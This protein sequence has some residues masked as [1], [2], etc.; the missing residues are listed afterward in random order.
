MCSVPY[1][2]RIV[3]ELAGEVG[4]VSFEAIQAKGHV[5]YR[6]GLGLN[7]YASF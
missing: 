7:K 1:S 3:N 4:T 5:H 6:S 2:V